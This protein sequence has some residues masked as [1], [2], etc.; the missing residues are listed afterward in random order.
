MSNALATQVKQL[1][2]HFELGSDPQELLSMLKQT[3]FSVSN[4]EITDEQMVALLIVANQ[5]KLN[6]WTR[7]IY[8]FPDKGKIVP[9]VGVDGW[10]RIINSHSQFDGMDFKQDD[11]SCTCIIYRK[12]RSH[13]VSVTEWMDECYREP[14]TTRQGQTIKGPW[15]THPKRM[16]RHKAMIQCA[17]LA[18]GFAGIFDEDEATRVREAENQTSA[19]EVDE[20]VRAELIKRAEEEAKKG[21]EAL[22]N[23]WMS[24]LSAEER[25]MIGKEEL[26][27]LKELSQQ[28]LEAE[29]EEVQD[30][31]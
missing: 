26:E 4:T 11:E 31:Q 9:I 14:F 10:A 1:S 29:Y 17:R 2:Q 23:F 6:P 5:Y 25:V 19:P 7:E 21:V 18:F 30:E 12:D 22:Q 24:C 16:L 15:Q 20:A 3:A 13:P 28:V 8:A 27:R